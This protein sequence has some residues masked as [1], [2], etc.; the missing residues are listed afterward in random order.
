MNRETSRRFDL[1]PWNKAAE[2][3]ERTH[4]AIVPVGAIEPHGRHAPLGTDTFIAHEI[5]ERLAEIADA[6][7]FPPLPLG[8][9]NLGYD[10]RS[11]P[12]TISLDA[13]VLIAL[14]TNIGTELARSGVRRIVFVNGHG[15]NA[16]VLGIASYQI[17]EKAPVEVGVLEW[18]TTSDDVVKEIKGF[19]FGTHGDEIET[20]IVMATAEACCVHLEEATIN[21]PTLEDIS[22]MEKALYRAKVPFTRTW[23]ARWIGTSGNM[24]DP[25]KATRDKGDRIIDRAVEVGV[26]LLGVLSEQLDHRARAA[27]ASKPKAD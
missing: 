24:G 22:P 20:S 10:F 3:I 19:S 14:Y 26:Q 8:V 1:L 12:G 17:R 4:T 16:A 7:V 5:A 15:P 2:A 25:T 11:L 9:M 6:V 21:S 13:N 18:W 27:A 23:D